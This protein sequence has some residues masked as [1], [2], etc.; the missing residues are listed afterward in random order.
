MFCSQRSEDFSDRF[1]WQYQAEYLQ[2]GQ[3]SHTERRVKLTPLVKRLSGHVVPLKKQPWPKSCS[4]FIGCPYMS[5]AWLCPGPTLSGHSGSTDTN[6][7]PVLTGQAT[8]LHQVLHHQLKT[9][10]DSSP[11]P[12]KAVGML[13]T[14]K[15]VK[16]RRVLVFCLM[17]DLWC[18]VLLDTHWEK[19]TALGLDLQG[20]GSLHR[21]LH[22]IAAVSWDN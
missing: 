8:P 18:P 21:M 17:F 22:A 12:C 2:V 19:H 6:N 13:L 14:R 11:T 9:W 10:P 15:L 20:N 5:P 3:Q 16:I 7:V 1:S 4:P